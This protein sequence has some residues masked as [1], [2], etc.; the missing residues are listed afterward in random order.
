MTR[1]AFSALAVLLAASAASAAPL[2]P[3]AK[4]GSWWSSGEVRPLTATAWLTETGRAPSFRLSGERELSLLSRYVNPSVERA[5]AWQRFWHGR[6][7]PR[8]GEAELS[9]SASACEPTDITASEAFGVTLHSGRLAAPRLPLLPI[10]GAD[11]L[12]TWALDVIPAPDSGALELSPAARCKPWQIPYT[13]TVAR[14]GGES[15][16]FSLLD[17]DGSIAIDAIDTLSVLARPPGTPRPELP[18]PIEPAIDSERHGEWLP[19]VRLLDPRLAWV[20]A[21]ISEAFPRRVIY[22]ISGYR[23]DAHDGFHHKARA[24]DMFVMGVKNEDL[25]QVCR[26]LRDVGCGYYP[27]NKFVHVDVRPPGTGH[28][29]WVDDSAPGQP[30]HYVDSW[31][32]V[33]SGGALVWAGGEG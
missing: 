5:D 17:C 22:L 16:T 32:G 23:R 9:W 24:L 30:S 21:S 2:W 1:A 15:A 8:H 4:D 19:A 29:M 13:V 25:F 7:S 33:V 3:K 14:Y 6:F 11:V 20:L 27:H 18:L 12:P 10:L 26:K 28:A 31:P